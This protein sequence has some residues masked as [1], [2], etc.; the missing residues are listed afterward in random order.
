MRLIDIHCH[1]LPRIDDGAESVEAS[2]EILKEAKKQGITRMIVTPH[3]RPDMF[4]PPMK[5]VVFAYRN[6][7]DIA[8]E[9]GIRLS[10]GCEYYRNDNMIEDLDGKLRPTLAG[11]RYVLTEFSTQDSFTTI[12]N[13]IYSLSTHGYKP[14]VAHVERYFCCQELE[15]VLE[16]KELGAC[17]QLNAGSVIGEDGWKIK[18]F[19][20]LLMK[21]DA[22]DFIA[23]DTHNTSNRKMNL[24]KCVAYVTKKMGKKYAKKVFT[25]NPLKIWESRCRV[26]KG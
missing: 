16:L 19:C 2:I 22:V 5:K 21:E 10:L 9:M 15:K 17:I 24:K 25:E 4:E 7:R 11:S 3:Y 6:L 14:V 1:T 12:R 20:L 13:Y 26:E 18:K 23:S 8:Y